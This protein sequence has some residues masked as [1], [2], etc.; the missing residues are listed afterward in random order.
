MNQAI[1]RQVFQ[2]RELEH[3]VSVGHWAYREQKLCALFSQRP[4]LFISAA[5]IFPKS[6]PSPSP[7][8]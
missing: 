1:N 5:K 8:I 2:G 7:L 6:D 4:T 3:L